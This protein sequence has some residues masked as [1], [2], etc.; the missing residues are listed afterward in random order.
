MKLGKIWWSFIWEINDY[1]CQV[2]CSAPDD[3]LGVTEYTALPL[4]MKLGHHKKDHIEHE[5]NNLICHISW[6]LIIV[7]NVKC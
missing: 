5:L 6:H 4:C 3:P 1:V 2:K 7:A